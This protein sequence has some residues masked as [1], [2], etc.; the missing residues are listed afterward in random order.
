M[1]T[2]YSTHHLYALHYP[3]PWSL[4]WAIIGSGA[5]SVAFDDCTAPLLIPIVTAT[6]NVTCV[7]YDVAIVIGVVDDE[8]NKL[9][10]IELV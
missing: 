2:H 5:I 1:M 9:H 7:F 8:N 10:C 4:I 6:D 3:I